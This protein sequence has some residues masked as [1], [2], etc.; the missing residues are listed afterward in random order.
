MDGLR[1][2]KKR[3]QFEAT[4][5]KGTR[6]ASK[7]KKVSFRD[8]DPIEQ[9]GRAARDGFDYQDNVAVA[10]CLAMIL[11]GGPIEV[12]CEAEDDIV[13]VWLNEQEE[14]F[15]FVQVKSNDLGQA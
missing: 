5:A 12:W 10:K 2:A 11:D 7:P 3:R 8:L 9:G 6:S 13:Q 15:E 1:L 4:M 14:W